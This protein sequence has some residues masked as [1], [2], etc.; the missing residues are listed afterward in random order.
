MRRRKAS[1][2]FSSG[3]FTFAFFRWNR[4]GTVTITLCGKR[5]KRCRFKARRGPGGKLVVL[6]DQEVE[7]G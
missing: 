7:W 2:I 1:E 3:D 6:E 5:G 4:D